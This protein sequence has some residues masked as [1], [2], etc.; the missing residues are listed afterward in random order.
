M[1][2]W[3]TGDRRACHV[4]PGWQ[5]AP[6]LRRA[7]CCAALQDT[8]IKVFA[9]D[10]QALLAEA[11]LPPSEVGRTSLGLCTLAFGSGS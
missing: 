4:C 2:K 10:E 5:Q 9:L 11:A 6:E 7:L 3:E 1:G 8:T